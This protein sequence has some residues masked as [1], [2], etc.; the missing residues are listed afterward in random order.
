MSARNSLG[1][2]IWNVSPV[3]RNRARSGISGEVTS[4]LSAAGSSVP[5]SPSVT[6]QARA[7]LHG[8]GLG[9]PTEVLLLNPVRLG[10]VIVGVLLGTLRPAAHFRFVVRHP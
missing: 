8:L 9:S 1:F 4:R 3:P 5:V 7:L 6:D 10:G 2:Q